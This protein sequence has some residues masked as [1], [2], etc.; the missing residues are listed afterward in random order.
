MKLEEQL[1]HCLME[2]NSRFGS[3]LSLGPGLTC[4]FRDSTGLDCHLELDIPR[5]ELCLCA[6]V[7]RIEPDQDSGKELQNILR[8]A[9]L[10]YKTQGGGLGL[11]PDNKR[12]FLWW[13]IPMENLDSVVLEKAVQRLVLTGRTIKDLLSS[14]RSDSGTENLPPDFSIPGALRI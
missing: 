1:S 4:P 3:K 10:G 6:E 5:E 13:R 11:A 9:F 12:L 8:L 7:A 2:F 14:A